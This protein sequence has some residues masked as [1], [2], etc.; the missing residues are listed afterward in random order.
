[1][2]KIQEAEKYF[3]DCVKRVD[4]DETIL[5]YNKIAQFAIRGMSWK[6]VK[7]ER[8]PFD[9][10]VLI[11]CPVGANIFMV[12]RSSRDGETYIWGSHKKLKYNITHWVE[13]PYSPTTC[14]DFGWQ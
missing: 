2:K 13:V 12:Y 14:S 9:R 8:L 4:L 7:D 5:N 10:C 11:F 6:S 3:E 1:M